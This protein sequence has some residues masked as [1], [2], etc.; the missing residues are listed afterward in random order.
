M[1]MQ[2]PEVAVS[3]SDGV[4]LPVAAGV[5]L[6]VAAAALPAPCA[7]D[8]MHVMP[9]APYSDDS[10][11]AAFERLPAA[12]LCQSACSHLLFGRRCRCV[13]LGPRGQVG[14]LEDWV[15]GDQTV[16]A[17]GGAQGLEDRRRARRKDGG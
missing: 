15:V 17:T 2:F 3:V 6:P 1:R 8:I 13:R 5:G 14:W 9:T 12:V 16:H 4:C 11:T 10:S 7:A